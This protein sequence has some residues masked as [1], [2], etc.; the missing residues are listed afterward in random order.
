MNN[1]ITLPRASG[2]FDAMA[3]TWNLATA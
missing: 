1:W 2:A 3:Q